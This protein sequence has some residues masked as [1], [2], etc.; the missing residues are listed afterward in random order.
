MHIL[1]KIWGIYVLFVVLRIDF[2]VLTHICERIQKN[3]TADVNKRDLLRSPIAPYGITKNLI[4][5]A[6]RSVISAVSRSKLS[7]VYV[8]NGADGLNERVFVL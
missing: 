4:L 3:E 6:K 2:F 7:A 8:Q 1:T 5:Y